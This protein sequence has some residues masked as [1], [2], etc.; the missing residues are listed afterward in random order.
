MTK[1]QDVMGSWPFPPEEKRPMLLRQSD[2]LHYLYPPDNARTSDN[3]YLFL[4]T[5][6]MLVGIYELAPGASFEPIDIHPGDES[7]FIL[8]G[9]VVQKCS[10]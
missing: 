5:D 9:P 8:E 7:Y 3:N 1:F 10:L 2:Y 4:S 6:T